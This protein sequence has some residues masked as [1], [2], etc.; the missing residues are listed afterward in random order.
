VLFFDAPLQSREKWE[1]DL[2]NHV[3]FI[4]TSTI[5]VAIEQC[6]KVDGPVLVGFARPGTA[7]GFMRELRAQKLTLPVLAVVDAGRPELAVEAVLAG[8]ADVL[9]FQASAARV[10]AAIRRESALPSNRAEG[11]GS[12]PDDLYAFSPAM[13]DVCATAMRTAASR[14]G[15]LLVGERGTG[16]EAVARAIH[17]AGGAQSGSFVKIDCADV[18][19]QQ[20][21][22]ELFG[23][24]ASDN[25][26]VP[27]RGLE[28]ISRGSR[29][30]AAIGGTL[31]L[32]N[33]AEAPTRVQFRLATL[34]RDREAALVEDGSIVALD[35]RCIT[36]AEGSIE[37]AVQ[38]GRLLPDLFRR[39]AAHRIDVPSLR[40]RREDI[41]PLANAFMR[42]ACVELGVPVK[43]FARSALALLAALPWGGNA[44]ELKTLIH[45]VVGALEGQA[46]GVDSLLSHMRLDAGTV[47]LVNRGTLREARERFEREY[48]AAS[49]RQHR[50]RITRAAKALGMQRANLYRKMRSLHVAPRG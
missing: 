21:G 12:G 13:R 20:L 47:A 32:Q 49:L 31:F 28:R 36:A 42:E 37:A 48:I 1:R 11:P 44:A 43:L 45:A 8:A 14:S 41:A 4:W 33:V 9:T 24:A 6:R 35:I 38:E 10:A 26:G 18:D 19:A 16:R 27:G 34:L 46:F 25:D 5:D 40:N 23:T 2:A 7:L 30:C 15:V 50:G 22:A 39:L 3:A 17:A 29:L